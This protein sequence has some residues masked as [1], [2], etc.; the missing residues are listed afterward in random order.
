MT[1]I[2]QRR[3]LQ[4]PPGRHGIETTSSIRRRST[5]CKIKYGLEYGGVRLTGADRMALADADQVDGSLELP[6][7][8]LNQRRFAD[9][10]APR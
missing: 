1:D 8:R 2:D 9:P 3:Q 6:Q 10:W 5:L 7:E 4:Q